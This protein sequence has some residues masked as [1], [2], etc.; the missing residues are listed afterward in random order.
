MQ[1]LDV[2]S[3]SQNLRRTFQ[4]HGFKVTSI[5]NTRYRNSEQDTLIM[6]FL[7]FDFKSY[8][9]AYFHV[10]FFGL[11]C[12]AFSKASGGHHFTS[13][14]E[15]KTEFANISLSL[16]NHVLSCIDHFKDAVF[17]IENP[18]GGL[19]HHRAIKARIHTSDLFMY[20]FF[21]SQFGFPTPKQ[22]DLFTNN[23]Q[24]ALFDRF[25]RKNNR[26]QQQK[27]YNLSDHQRHTY[28]TAFCDFIY[29]WSLLQLNSKSI[30][31][32]S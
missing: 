3:G 22:T 11:P 6:D 23:N 25:Y 30:S 21:M 19:C 12:D 15:P 28:P 5:D 8:D 10:L 1:L 4:S 26:Y 32:V 24:L 14:L 27:F 31:N 13:S 29:K 18:S 17:Y 16:L 9:Q 20:R 2:F 7:D